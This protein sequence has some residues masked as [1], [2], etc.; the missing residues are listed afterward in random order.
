MVTKVSIILQTHTVFLKNQSTTPQISQQLPL[1]LS[2]IG[3]PNV[4]TSATQKA[5]GK[6][7][8]EKK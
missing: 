4:R 6:R 7:M 8:V 1:K 3:K 5:F 2:S